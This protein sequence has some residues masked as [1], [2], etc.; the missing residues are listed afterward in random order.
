[1]KMMS[2]LRKK[3]KKVE[4]DP[5][6]QSISTRL[7]KQEYDE[8]LKLCEDTGYSVSEGLRLLIQ[9]EIKTKDDEVYTKRLQTS[10]ERLQMNTERLQM[11]TQRKQTFTNVNIGSRFTTNEWKIGNELPCPICEQWMSA[12]NFS[13]HA[14]SHELTT[15]EIF[16]KHAEKATQLYKERIE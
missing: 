3:S 4:K 10:T 13:R 16:T 6:I 8:F 12:A 9:Q 2:L 1:V 11:N 14:K 15:K 5:R 7:T